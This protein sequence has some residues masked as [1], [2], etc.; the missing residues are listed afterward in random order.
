MKKYLLLIGLGILL[1]TGCGKKVEPPKKEPIVV[2]VVEV[3][4]TVEEEEVVPELTVYDWQQNDE[5]IKSEKAHKMVVVKDKRV[6]VLFNEEGDTLSRHRVSLG[7]N[8]VGT[9]L[10]QGDKKTPEGVYGIR[11]IRGDKKYYK[12]ILIDYPNR[13]D[14]KRSKNLG[15]NPGG[16]ITF[17]AQVNWNWNGSGDDYT[18]SNDW[19]NGCIALTNHGMNT[20]LSM[21][22]KNTIV[23]IRE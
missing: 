12:E 14:V 1:F 8:P 6:L 15:F 5:L 20:V 10:K 11:D 18:L 22:D 7:E 21:I 23:E 9:K 2:V 17:H 19:T 16:G 13:H 4:E 3:N